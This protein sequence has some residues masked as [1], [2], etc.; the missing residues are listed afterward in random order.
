[1]EYRETKLNRSFVI[2]FDHGEDVLSGIQQV[3]R[4]EKL[5]SGL[6]FLVGALGRAK[7]VTG[8]ERQEI[9][10]QPH[11]VAFDDGREILAIGTIFRENDEP[12][13]HLHSAAGRG[14]HAFA[15]CIREEGKVFLTVE[16]VILE[17]VGG[18]A[19]RAFDPVAGLSLLRFRPDGTAP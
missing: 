11:W 7:M 14:D 17:L 12:K 1:M 8:P 16:A 13:I 18:G 19:V 5:E 4:D 15:G 9:P 6:V 10:P 3:A 2:R